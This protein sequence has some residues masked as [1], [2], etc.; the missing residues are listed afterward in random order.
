VEVE[1]NM[2]N[3]LALVLLLVG[4]LALGQ[5]IRVDGSST[6]YPISL[7]LGEDFQIIN[8]RARVTVAFSGTGA[9]FEKFCRG[10]TDASGASRP[11]KQGEID[12]CAQNGI[13]FV[14]VPVAADGLSVVVNPG[15][16]WVDCLS[17]DELN[18]IWMPG[19]Q[20]T[21]WSDVRSD[22]PQQEI[23]LYGPGT[24]SGTFDYFTEA[25]NGDSGA[26]RTDFFPSEDD[27]VLV[28]GVS[29]QKNAMAFFG[30]AYY[31]ENRNRL[32]LVAID[33]GD[34]C[35]EPSAETIAGNTYTPLSRPMFLYFNAERLE[36]NPAVRQFAEFTVSPDA[37]PL[38]ADTG[39]LSY[40]AEI[41]D[42]AAERIANAVT[43][44]AFLSFKPGDSVLEAV[45]GDR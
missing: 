26:I 10:E 7:A 30:F 14:E 11:I 38:I 17:L 13:E 21:Y 19:S 1:L 36:S 28:Q 35:V 32:K 6:V 37:E 33:G 5:D 43:G 40:P 24:D 29:G 41:Y 16:D 2:K 25:V 42:A 27:N 45:R 23:V 39:Y 34:G 18:A 12:L 44:S 15:N 3:L 9:G 8:P 4:S 31:T 20:V 22:W